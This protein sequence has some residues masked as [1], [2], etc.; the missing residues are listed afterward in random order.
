VA[1]KSKIVNALR[2]AMNFMWLTQAEHCRIA[3]GQCTASD[4]IIAVGTPVQEPIEACPHIGTMREALNSCGPEWAITELPDNRISVRS[5]A[6][7]AVVPCRSLESLPELECSPSAWPIDSRLTDGL[8]L[9][10]PLVNEKADRLVCAT[11]MV[12]TGSLIATNGA[13]IFQLWHGCSLPRIILPK[14]AVEILVKCKKKP[15]GIGWNETTATFWFE[16][17]SWIKTKVF[18]D[19]WPDITA[20]LPSGLVEIKPFPLHFF[21]V[22]AEIGK[23]SQVINC[24]ENMVSSYDPFLNLTTGAHREI[25]LGGIPINK[26]YSSESLKLISKYATH[27]NDSE[28]PNGTLFF[29]TNIRGAVFHIK[30]QKRESMTLK[31]EPVPCTDCGGEWRDGKCINCG[32][33]IPF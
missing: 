23:F 26:A 8:R 4:G 10:L 6:F 2:D 19:E 22:A 30:L 5:G 17:Q 9:A 25:E 16:D 11:V 13:I 14:V 12:K 28:L 27:F 15:V 18:P 29:G 20:S 32:N 31:S 24:G 21:D 3:N 1:K 33:D 7:Q